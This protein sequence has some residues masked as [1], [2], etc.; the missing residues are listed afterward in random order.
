MVW[1]GVD[2]VEIFSVDVRIVF[3]VFASGIVSDV[4]ELFLEVV[5]VSYAVFVIAAVPDFSGGLLACREGVAAF[6]ELNA[7]RC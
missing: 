1:D 5:G 6:D 7:F 2:T 4:N 3:V